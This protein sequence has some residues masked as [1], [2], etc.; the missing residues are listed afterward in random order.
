MSSWGKAIGFGA[1]VWLVPFVIAFAAFPLRDPARAVFES[2]MSVA[3]AFAAVL[4]G[5]LY[6]R[7]VEGSAVREGL[8]VGVLWF[9]M[10]VAIDAPLMLLGGPMRMSF[11]E[12][13]G[14]IGLT[15]VGIPVITAG[16]GW[17]RSRAG[18][19]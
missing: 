14:D 12:Y 2:I 19:R 3:V 9:A 16:L 15:Y 7:G 13:M 17:V 11:G 8:V 1:L 6:L 18:D 4:F 5:V 10:C